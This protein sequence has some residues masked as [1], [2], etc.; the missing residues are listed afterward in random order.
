MTF[1]VIEKVEPFLAAL[2]ALA[3]ESVGHDCFVLREV[4]QMTRILHAIL[5]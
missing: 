4:S 1:G 3:C 2:I 5:A